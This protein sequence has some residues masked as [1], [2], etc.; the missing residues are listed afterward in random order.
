MDTTSLQGEHLQYWQAY[1]RKREQDPDVSVHAA[2][3]GDKTIADSLLSLY[4]QGKKTA[5]S[6]LVRDYVEAEDPLPKVGDYWI[7]LNAQNIP[8]C[9]VR[10]VAVE[11]HL[12]KDVPLRI[13][14]A[15]GE[16]D[17]SLEYWR[18]GHRRFFE[19]YF[20][21]DNLDEEQIITEFFEVVYSK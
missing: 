10:T 6:G 18:E 7:I 13:A 4:L 15:E 1:C 12:F 20:V 17:L 5:G 16:G 14:V 11:I 8:K 2:M 19:K 21:L 3:A 9:I